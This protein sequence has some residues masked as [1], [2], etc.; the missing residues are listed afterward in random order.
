MAKL[1]I[2]YALLLALSTWIAPSV[3]LEELP[4]FGH[5]KELVH[6]GAHPDVDAALNTFYPQAVGE[7]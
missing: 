6:Q 7:M 3:Q 1:T 5:V 4:F 2:T